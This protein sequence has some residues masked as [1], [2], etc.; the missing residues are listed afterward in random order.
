MP[1]ITVQ[2]VVSYSSADKGFPAD[3]LLKAEGTH[4]WKTTAPVDKHATAV[5]QFEKASH[6]HSIDIGNEGSAFVEVLVGKSSAKEDK[7]YQVLLVASSFMSPM[8]SRNNTNRNS[9]RMFGKEKLSKTTISE[10]WDRVKVVCTQP[11]NKNSGY[12]L[13]FIKFHSPPAPGEKDEPAVGVKKLGAFL[14]KPEKD[15]DIQMGSAFAKRADVRETPPATGAAAIRA[16][17]RLSE[18]SRSTTALSPATLH[19]SKTCDTVSSLKSETIESSSSSKAKLSS[20]KAAPKMSENRSKRKHEFSDDEGHYSDDDDSPPARPPMKKQSTSITS[21]ASSVMSDTKTALKKNKSEPARESPAKSFKKLLEGVV[22]SLSGFQNPF[23]GELRDMA[24]EMGGVYK[25]DW[26]KTCTH[27]ICAFTNTPKYNQV[28]GKGRIVK[29][30]WVQ[31]CYKQKKRLPWR[32]Y[33]LGDTDYSSDEEEDEPVMKKTPSQTKHKEKH[34]SKDDKVPSKKES[35]P[36][37]ADMEVYDDDTDVDSG[38][39]TEDEVR[40]IKQKMEK[41]NKPKIDDEA[42]YGDST[43]NDEESPKKSTHKEVKMEADDG[44]DNDCGLP[45]LSDLFTSKN[46]FL[47]GDF[48]VSERRLLI[49]YITAYN[50]ELENYMTDKVNFV[51]TYSKWDDNFDEA[52]AD[53]SELVFVKPKWIYS[54]HEKNKTMPFQP[55]IVVPD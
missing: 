8:D 55:Y 13:S 10:K 20:T 29:K 21:T 46:F 44:D 41:N 26:D 50:G 1:E 39:D 6:I 35:T 23:R 2:H 43:D 18:E 9:V 27:L 52:L 28:K 36:K 31:H 30:D 5:L 7:D 32:K 3:N 25:A 16:A 14:I 19:K 47:Y 51:V 15:D 38:E 11:F 17:S 49:R 37:K 33:V 4:K 24:T 22:F 45:E 53:N 48:S 34:G 42:V 40:R 54:C 12:G